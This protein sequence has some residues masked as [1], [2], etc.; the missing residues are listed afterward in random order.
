MFNIFISRVLFDEISDVK[1]HSSYNEIICFGRL[2]YNSE[3]GLLTRFFFTNHCG[4][5]LVTPLNQPGT[6]LLYRI[7]R[8]ILTLVPNSLDYS[9]KPNNYETNFSDCNDC[10]AGKRNCCYSIWLNIHKYVSMAVW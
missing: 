9:I 4:D 2:L 3:S 10:I 1:N 6:N 5:W 7:L 8:H